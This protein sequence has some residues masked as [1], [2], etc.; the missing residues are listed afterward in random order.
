[1]NGHSLTKSHSINGLIK[2][3]KEEFIS[4]NKTLLELP[5]T[6][7]ESGE[8]NVT[9]DITRRSSTDYGLIPSTGNYMMNDSINPLVDDNMGLQK[10]NRGISSLPGAEGVSPTKEKITQGEVDQLFKNLG[11]DIPDEIS[12]GGD[13]GQN[14]DDLFRVFNNIE[15]NTASDMAPLGSTPSDGE[16]IFPSGLSSL[17]PEDVMINMCVDENLVNMNK[18]GIIKE[19]LD[20]ALKKQ[21]QLKRKCDFLMRRLRKL[22]SRTLGKHVCDEVTGILEYTSN[23]FDAFNRNKAIGSSESSTDIDCEVKSVTLSALS[24]LMRQMEHSS[25]QQAS[26]IAKNANKQKYFGAGPSTSTATTNGMRIPGT[27]I[28]TFKP[29]VK[30]EICRVTGELSSQLS[31]LES[32]IDSD[33]TASSSGCDSSDELV[34]YNNIHQ[35]HTPM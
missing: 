10:D 33:L 27:I 34:S 35:Q 28:P 2:S 4:L 23:L 20:E 31:M 19:K 32:E 26:Y 8:D 13:L 11:V 1:M 7:N 5:K 16:G 9:V 15:S 6:E 17:F 22:Q 24:L 18:E 29:E 14:V 30:K 3:N 12:G 21:F 25:S